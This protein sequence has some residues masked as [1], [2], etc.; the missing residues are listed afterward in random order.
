[1]STGNRTNERLCDLASSSSGARSGPR[2][3]EIPNSLLFLK[4]GLCVELWVARHPSWNLTMT[5][6][7]VRSRPRLI[8]SFFF[9]PPRMGSVSS[10]AELPTTSHGPGEKSLFWGFPP[11]GTPFSRG[12]SGGPW[13]G[14]IS[15]GIAG[16][17]LAALSPCDKRERSFVASA[18]R[19]GGDGP[20]RPTIPPCQAVTAPVFS[21][22]YFP[23]FRLGFDLPGRTVCPVPPTCRLPLLRTNLARTVFFDGRLSPPPFSGQE[24]TFPDAGFF[25][26]EPFS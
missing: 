15:S 4:A 25:P 20:F 22:R 16:S 2:S 14:T 23:L 1:V 13:Y 7:L 3:G 8:G 12:L 5:P 19:Y 26:L 21:T 17:L 11:P 6:S 10:L 24:S 9:L 18:S